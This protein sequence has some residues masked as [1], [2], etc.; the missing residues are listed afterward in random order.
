MSCN[1]YVNVLP[2]IKLFGFRTIII[3]KNCYSSAILFG[4]SAIMGL[5]DP[6]RAD[7]VAVNGEVAGG[8]AL[9]Y[10]H[11]RMKESSEGRLILKERPRITTKTV[12]YDALAALP[13]GTLGR[14]NRHF[15]LYLDI[16]FNIKTIHT[17]FK[18]YDNYIL[19]KNR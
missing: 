11:S 13:E 16:I 5:Y 8:P 9:S 1:I 18:S 12:D 15:S 3:M 4:G 10:M 19:L 6:W 2:S 7:M 17:K 14:V